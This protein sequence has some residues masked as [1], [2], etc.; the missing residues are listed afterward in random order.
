MLL[1]WSRFQRWRRL[2][3]MESSSL[4]VT[5]LWNLTVL[6]FGVLAECRSYRC[7]CSLRHWCCSR[8]H[9]GDFALLVSC[10]RRHGCCHVS[11]VLMRLSMFNPKM[12]VLIVTCGS[13]GA[14]LWVIMAMRKKEMCSVI[15][16]YD[17]GLKISEVLKHP[18]SGCGGKL[19]L[20]FSKLGKTYATWLLHYQYRQLLPL[21][22][23]KLI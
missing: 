4:E 6:S 3:I 18:L 1:S 14:I 16:S 23:E 10:H 21:L 19:H 5:S 2:S 12:G 8:V 20:C 22:F 11:Y 13:L 9:C 7:H 17:M 15:G